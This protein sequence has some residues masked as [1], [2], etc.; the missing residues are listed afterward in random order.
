M[1]DVDYHAGPME[2]D[3]KR[4]IRISGDGPFNVAVS[5]F[6]SDPPPPGVR[7]WDASPNHTLNENEPLEIV[8]DEDFWSRHTGG[9]QIDI[10]DSV[11]AKRRLHI[12]VRPPTRGIFGS[13]VR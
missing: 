9:F 11:G 6:V 1:I 2:L 12:N 3:E 5:V 7:P 4:T 10:V 8:A 13:S